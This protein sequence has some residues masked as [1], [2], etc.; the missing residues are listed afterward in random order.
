MILRVRHQNNYFGANL[1]FPGLGDSW[2]FLLGNSSIEL[3]FLI[4]PP[5]LSE[6]HQSEIAYVPFVLVA[7]Y[8]Y[9]IIKLKL[10]YWLKT[11]PNY[12]DLK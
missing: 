11:L 10:L 12:I 5:L 6:H 2:K 4:P 1:S 3:G 7:D 8:M 9:I